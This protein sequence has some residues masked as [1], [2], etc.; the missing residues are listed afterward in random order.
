MNI[1]VRQTLSICFAL[2]VAVA[3][4][5]AELPQ[6]VNDEQPFTEVRRLRNPDTGTRWREWEVLTYADDHRVKH[7]T[8]FTWHPNEVLAQ[9][10]HFEHGEL[11]GRMQSWHEDG[12]LRSRYSFGPEGQA[13]LL[14]FWY[15]AGDAAH[16]TDP[17]TGDPLGVLSAEGDAIRGQ[18][19]G[20]W[21]FYHPTGA[22]SEEGEYRGGLREALWSEYHE[23]GTLTARGEY[24]RGKKTGT[25]ERHDAPRDIESILNSE[26]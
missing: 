20:A 15:P 19:V 16:E 18:R 4:R 9:E 10:R 14:R 17:A 12:S 11:M 26:R 25:W 22:L 7:G 2:L 13:T 3:C 6:P 1:N 21:R 5:S 24:E 23:S 8:E